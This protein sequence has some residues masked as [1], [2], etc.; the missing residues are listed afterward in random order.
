MK[1]QSTIEGLFCWAAKEISAL[2]CNIKRHYIWKLILILKASSVRKPVGLPTLSLWLKNC[3]NFIAFPWKNREKV[4]LSMLLQEKLLYDMKKCP[5]SPSLSLLPLRLS[6][7]SYET[8]LSG[9]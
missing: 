2:L 8:P 1:S 4:F 6:V 5:S 7:A 3:I 9:C